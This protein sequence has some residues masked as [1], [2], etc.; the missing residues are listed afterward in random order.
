[1]R[2]GLDKEYETVS[3][4]LSKAQR[5]CERGWSFFTLQVDAP[6]LSVYWGLQGQGLALNPPADIHYQ[7]LAHSI[8]PERLRMAIAENVEVPG[9]AELFRRNHGRE[10][11]LG[12]YCP[13]MD[14]LVLLKRLY[15]RAQVK[16]FD[17][18]RTLPFSKETV[19]FTSRSKS[20]GVFALKA[21]HDSE[22]PMQI[23]FPLK[24][25][26]QSRSFD[27]TRGPFDLELM[28]LDGDQKLES[29]GS[30]LTLVAQGT[31]SD[32][33]FGKS[34][35]KPG[36]FPLLGETE[37]RLQQ[38]TALSELADEMALG[39]KGSE[40]EQIVPELFAS[41]GHTGPDLDEE[42]VLDLLYRIRTQ[43]VPDSLLLQIN[44]AEAA[45]AIYRYLGGLGDKFPKVAKLAE[46][47]QKRYNT[48][49]LRVR[50]LQALTGGVAFDVHA[51]QGRIS[52]LQI[53]AVEPP[54]IMVAFPPDVDHV[55][56]EVKEYRKY[57]K[58]QNRILDKGDESP[59]DRATLEYLEKL[60]EERLHLAE[61]RERLA[62]LLNDLD[63]SGP[64]EDKG[65]LPFHM[66]LPYW[67]RRTVEFLRIPDLVEWFRSKFGGRK[68]ESSSL[69]AG[70][71]AWFL[72]PL[73][74]LLL[75]GA[76][77]VG[78]NAMGDSSDSSIVSSIKG[79]FQEDP[80]ANSQDL[81][82]LNGE[83]GQPDNALRIAPPGGIQENGRVPGEEN[84]VATDQEIFQFSDL[85]ARRNG[86]APLRGE[87]PDL[88]NP[89]LVF[90]GDKL[91]LPDGRILQITPGQYI[92]DVARK[93]YRKDMARLQILDKQIHTL[94]AEYQK[95][96]SLI[97]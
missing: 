1:G 23:L 7:F 54:K 39:L 88:R 10:G 96:K 91:N 8:D 44:L 93:Q 75:A 5:R 6:L 22:H 11:Q 57:L 17:D 80:G 15:N 72:L 29:A 71:S 90:P 27:F 74:A 19:F 78:Y 47:I 68:S 50:D 97:S 12:A 25:T 52:I 53:H 4:I 89:D 69:P 59:S 92:W 84:V 58:E 81:V 60:L 46:K 77:F 94:G 38:V 62:D 87:N 37:Y 82:I 14:R 61:E 30:F 42:T 33:K 56:E 13:E 65:D 2:M 86:F 34:K 95:K 63:L 43:A 85:L 70:V 31:A 79:W 3:K 40:F 67:L 55:R 28:N 35:L 49:G 16:T 32:K 76:G 26:K 51:V 9:L 73:A 41:L 48:S 20:H 66:K 83:N 64:M 24:Q 45:R 18:S 36:V 21:N